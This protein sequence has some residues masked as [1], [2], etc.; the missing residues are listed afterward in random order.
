M[1]WKIN[2]SPPYEGG[3]AVWGFG[4]TD[5]VV[6][7]VQPDLAASLPER[8]LLT[9]IISRNAR[10]ELPRQPKRLPPLLRKEGSFGRVPP[11]ICVESTMKRDQTCHRSRYSR[12]NIP[13]TVSDLG[14]GIPLRANGNGSP[15]YEGGVAVWGFGQTDGVVLYVTASSRGEFV[16]DALFPWQWLSVTCREPPRQ[17]KRLPPLL[18]KEGSFGRVPRWL[19]CILGQ[20]MPN[21]RS[22][23]DIHSLPK[24]KGFR[25]A[26]R[27]TL[28]PAE[29]AF[30][31]IVKN[32]NLDGRK[33]RRQHGIGSFIFDFYC[34]SERLAIELDGEWHYVDHPKVR[35][36]PKREFANAKG[37]R[38]IRFENKRVFEEPEWV[39]DV[40]R[41]HFGW[42]R[43]E[44]SKP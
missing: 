37:I 34:P 21:K 9:R 5:G 38:V 11:A 40:I 18:R 39:V 41:S 17:P 19:M 44:G 22:P 4:Q 13:T 25:R 16:C 20:T 1:G 15:P 36:K 31:S 35:D 12:L 24:T 14:C 42:W 32:G 2:G 3:V 43:V 8:I 23:T 33:F 30:W 27:S 6:L 28:T 29:A 7:Y 26:L 10:R